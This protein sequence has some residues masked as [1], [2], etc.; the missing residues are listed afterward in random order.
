MLAACAVGGLLDGGISWA[1]QR[2]SGRKVNWGQVGN[3]ALTG[4]MLG[5]AGEALGAFMAARGSMRA[6]SCLSPNSFTA[7]TPVLMAD[8]TRKPIKDIKIG[9]KVLS[10]DPDTGETGPRAV[11]ALI[12]GNGEKQ[13]VDL[14]IDTDQ[15]QNAKTGNI[16]ATDGHPFW[17]PALHQWVEAGD[18]KAGQL[19][20]TSAGTW[21]QITATQ[22]R[23]QSTKV[24][25]LT[26]NDLHTYYVLAGTTPILVHN[27]D[28]LPT[29]LQ[30]RNQPLTSKQAADL[31]DYLGYRDAGQ[32]LKGQKIFT[33]GK[34][35]ISQDIGSGDGSHNGGTWKIANSIKAL[36]SK[37][38]RTAT[39]DALLTP[40]GC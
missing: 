16:T 2:L 31:A 32:R 12:E 19:L 17:V 36:G 30:G 37:S 33:N 5:M 10:T 4:C 26:I 14:T 28:P 21:V 35:F 25:N 11:T 6:G 27:D 15:T 20:Q 40:I 18:L 24:Y 22:H 3:A 34:K 13:L 39:T 38:S 9:D 1:S 23:T 8:G 29:Q 7:D